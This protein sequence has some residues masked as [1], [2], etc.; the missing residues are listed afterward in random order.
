MSLRAFDLALSRA[1]GS[2]RI[3]IGDGALAEALP[4]LGDWLEGRGVFVVSTPRVL[5]LHGSA[6]ENLKA[7]A[8]RWSV[9]EVPEGEAAK[10]VEVAATLWSRLVSEGVKRDSR[11]IGFGGGSVGDLGGFVAATVLRGIEFALLPTTVL[12]QVD[13]SIGGKTAIDLPTAKNCIG[14]FHSPRLVVSE[15]RWLATLDRAEA[16]AGWVEAIKKAMAFD[17]AL[18]ESFESSPAIS[19]GFD[20]AAADLLVAS[21]AHKIEVV[22]QDPF[23]SGDRRLLNLGHTLGHAIETAA[24]CGVLRHGECVAYGLLF[25]LRLGEARGLPPGEAARVRRLLARLEP[26]PLPDLDATQLSTLM[27]RDKKALEGGLA[28]VL[29]R[30]LGQAAL[31]VV[32]QA[33]V[34]ALLPRFLRAPWEGVSTSTL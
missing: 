11:L 7:R 5:A 4:A 15:T 22:R 17:R 20:A 28:W 25:A 31:E 10:S 3:W 6:L 13:A 23:E 2:S 14:A 34:E 19:Q 29:P 9:I 33:E 26:P 8:C 18:F 27:A 24:G 30:R 12:A 32:A 16:R 1:S 21:A